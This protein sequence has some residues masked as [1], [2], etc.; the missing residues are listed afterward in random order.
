VTV[1]EWT[2]HAEARLTAAGIEGARLEAQILAGHVLGVNRARLFAHPDAEFPELAA[3]ALLQ[4]R[5]A[6]EPLAYLLGKRE[7]YGRE[8]FVGPGVLIPR[9]ETETLVETALQDLPQGAYVLDLGTGSGC[10]GLTLKLERPD[11][12]VTLSDISDRALSI[13]ERNADALGAKVRLVRS[14][15][16]EELLG[17]AFDRIV[18]NPPYIGRHEELMPEVADHEPSE[19]LYSGETGM[20][21]YERLARQASAYLLDGGRVFME[22][23]HRQASSVKALFESEGWR[24]VQ[25]AADLSGVDRVVEMAVVHACDTD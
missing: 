18:T 11:L 10:I 5:E 1:G 22:V 9:Q 15:G 13:A 16:F 17:E 14:D 21:F 20:E 25:T 7:F 6:R 8:F 3:E 19:A 4:R 23:G 12:D 2:R 24:H